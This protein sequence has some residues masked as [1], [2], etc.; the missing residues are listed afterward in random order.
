MKPIARNAMSP[1]WET[2]DRFE[3]G[4]GQSL[5][6]NEFFDQYLAASKIADTDGP[7]I[8]RLSENSSSRQE[9]QSFVETAVAKSDTVSNEGQGSSS[10]APGADSAAF[11]GDKTSGALNEEHEA[12]A[13]GVIAGVDVVATSAEGTTTLPVGEVSVADQV[14]EVEGADEGVK[15]KPLWT[16]DAPGDASK[17]IPGYTE[18]KAARATAGEAKT[19]WESAGLGGEV[20]GD[21]SPT[22]LNRPSQ[23][24]SHVEATPTHEL[25]GGESPRPSDETVDGMELERRS[26]PKALRNELASS[27]SFEDV[28]GQ[29]HP[30]KQGT[31]AEGD[32]FLESD[33]GEALL[34]SSADAVDPVTETNRSTASSRVVEP[35]VPVT[36]ESNVASDV[37]SEGQQAVSVEQES[38]RFMDELPPASE[39]ASASV[40]SPI[41]E[42]AQ[43][44]A[45]SR[46]HIRLNSMQQQ[47]MLQR[48]TKAFE[49]AQQRGGEIRLRLS[50]PALGSL[51]VELKFEG[52]QMSARLEAEHSQARQLI[53]E[54]LP[55]LRDR[56]AEQGITIETFDVDLYHDSSGDAQYADHESMRDDSQSRYS[57]STVTE[58]TAES[59]ASEQAEVVE[60][61][62]LNVVV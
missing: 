48:V 12:D 56:L 8:C 43:R 53:M 25:D 26:D 30:S 16:S 44:A 54:H 23:D 58:A 39:R 11:V 50:P 51:K 41:E 34:S 36:A 10:D 62:S 24:E 57:G 21:A 2:K 31:G 59:N 49:L 35:M 17:A 27:S 47:R 55:A 61:G 5:D 1:L 13:A 28:S 33:P 42:T 40:E 45:E 22:E 46:H 15:D 37:P 60:D 14:A 19:T 29:R 3:P 38:S 7:I 4:I 20:V 32:A 9:P 18:A 6:S 52:Q